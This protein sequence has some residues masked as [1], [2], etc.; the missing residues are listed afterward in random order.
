MPYYSRFC[1][2]CGFNSSYY[3]I[4]KLLCI[5][6]KLCHVYIIS[7]QNASKIMKIS[8][9]M[10]KLCRKLKWLVFFLGHGVYLLGL[11]RFKMFLLWLCYCYCS[12]GIIMDPAVVLGLSIRFTLKNCQK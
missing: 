2:S 11:I 6:A 8:R 3:H 4:S 9:H 1:A 12:D 5:Y 10:A 7:E